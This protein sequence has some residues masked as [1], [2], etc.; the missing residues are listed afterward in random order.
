M[1]KMRFYK[2]I[3]TIK[4]MSDFICILIYPFILLYDFFTDNDADKINKL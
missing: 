2:I 3:I 1:M 4:N